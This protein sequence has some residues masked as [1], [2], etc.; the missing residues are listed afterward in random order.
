MSKDSEEPPV[1]LDSHRGMAAQAAT[2]ARRHSSAVEAD[3][4]MLRQARLEMER[5]LFAAPSGSWP[6]AAEK[7]GF[8]LRRFAATGDAHD[9]R[10]RKMI[11]AVLADFRRL[12]S[13]TAPGRSG[14]GKGGEEG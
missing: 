1:E 7:A 2:E 10:I 6:E 3:Q 14:D 12:A 9:P 8:L 4:E 5:Y 11:A 13:E